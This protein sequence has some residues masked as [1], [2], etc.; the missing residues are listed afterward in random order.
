VFIRTD[1]KVWWYYGLIDKWWCILVVCFRKGRFIAIEC[2]AGK[3]T[4]TALQKYNI[5]QIKA[6]QGLA[7]VINEGN[8]EELLT[9]V[10]EEV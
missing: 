8:I 7:I 9:L 5:D 10:K 4:I 1:I 6:N 3:G 2:K